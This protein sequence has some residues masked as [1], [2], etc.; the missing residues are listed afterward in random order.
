MTP[1]SPPSTPATAAIP[2]SPA[3]QQHRWLFQ[4][5]PPSWWAVGG[6]L[7]TTAA[8]LSAAKPPSWWRSDDGTSTTTAPYDVGCDGATPSEASGR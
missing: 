8:G 3:P 7:A 2:P 4:P 6:E 5:L 1:S